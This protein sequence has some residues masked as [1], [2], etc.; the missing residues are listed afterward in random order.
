MTTKTAHWN[1][2]TPW[3][4]PC[5]FLPFDSVV[6]MEIH[7]SKVEAD[8]AKRREHEA[9]VKGGDHESTTVR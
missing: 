7:V 6:M 2:E 1:R 3:V 8:D 9:K 4:C 5:H